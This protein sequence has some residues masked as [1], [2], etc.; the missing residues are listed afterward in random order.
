[1]TLS[2][3]PLSFTFS[4]FPL[5]F[6]SETHDVPSHL[7]R[8]ASACLKT[9]KKG[10]KAS[11]L[12]SQSLI[13]ELISRCLR[14]QVRPDLRAAAPSILPHHMCTTRGHRLFYVRHSFSQHHVFPSHRFHSVS[15]VA[16][17]DTSRKK[18]RLRIEGAD[19]GAI[20]DMIRGRGESRRRAF[21]S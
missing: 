8:H 9:K 20:A 2:L 6:T 7:Q 13:T 12:T 3:S 10:S 1:M 11:L 14:Y 5:S 18:E 16:D 15:V 19:G 4:S 17:S 21:P